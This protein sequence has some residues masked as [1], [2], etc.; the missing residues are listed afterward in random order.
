[1]LLGITGAATVALSGCSEDASPQPASTETI[2]D[3][4]TTGTTLEVSLAEETA[5]DQITVLTPEGRTYATRDVAPGATQASV[6]L[7]FTYD[8]G[9][10]AVVAAADGTELERATVELRPDIMVRELRTGQTVADPPETLPYAEEQLVVTVENTG[11]GPTATTDLRIAGGVP[12]PTESETKRASGIHDQQDGYGAAD[13][14]PLPVGET[15]VLWSTT[16][17]FLFPDGGDNCPE[18]ETQRTATS[19]LE[20]TTGPAVTSSFS[21]VYQP[22]EDGDCTVT[23][24]GGD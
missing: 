7:P 21:V 12:N 16:S 22:S 17:P 3:L 10:F 4:T 11:S 6:E 23:L 19:T 8:S 14:V 20:F 2:T 9:D 18:T 1:M 5:V 15:R 24:G 13:R